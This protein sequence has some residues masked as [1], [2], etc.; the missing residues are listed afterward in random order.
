MSKV[1]AAP[2]GGQCGTPLVQI[3]EM[4]KSQLDLYDSSCFNGKWCA[5]DCF[6]YCTFRL[7]PRC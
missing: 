6:H 5:N 1:L 4:L 7:S 3:Y 2:E